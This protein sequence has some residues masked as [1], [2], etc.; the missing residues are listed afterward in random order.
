M[1]GDLIEPLEVYNKNYQMDSTDSI[2]IG[3]NFYDA[4]HDTCIKQIEARD[5]FYKLKKEALE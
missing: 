1:V 3:K 5:K 4:Y 2:Q